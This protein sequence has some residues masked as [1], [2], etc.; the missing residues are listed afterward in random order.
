MTSLT[1][2]LFILALDDGS[3]W[4]RAI[5]IATF[6]VVGYVLAMWAA[7]V[8]WAYRDACAR[9]ADPWIRWGSA[10]LVGICNIP[11]LLL[12]LAVRPSEPMVERYNR[13]L[14]AEAFLRE[15][16][17]DTACSSCRRAVDAEFAYCPYC[18]AE[19]QSPC[20]SCARMVRSSW[21]L[22]AYCATPHTPESAASPRALAGGV[23]S[24]APSYEPMAT[25]IRRPVRGVGATLGDAVQPMTGPAGALG[26]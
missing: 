15:V 14:E 19:L 13:Q 8:A 18:T 25:P 24:S 2:P 23:P 11:G 9:T 10:A 5:T 12:Y 22:C 7:M 1:S 17:K 3:M 4:I 21:T 26:G 16:R 6:V 20:G